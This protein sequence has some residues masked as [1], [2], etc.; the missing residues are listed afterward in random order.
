MWLIF[1]NILTYKEEIERRRKCFNFVFHLK[2][3]CVSFSFIEVIYTLL[4]KASYPDL[5][6]LDY[7]KQFH[8]TCQ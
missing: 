6:K 5:G 2:K 3:I 4:F 1:S 7:V 8:K